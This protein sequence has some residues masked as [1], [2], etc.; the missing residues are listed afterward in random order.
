MNIAEAMKIAKLI[1]ARFPKLALL[2]GEAGILIEFHDFCKQEPLATKE[3]VI[4]CLRYGLP[5][6]SLYYVKKDTHRSFMLP[7]EEYPEAIKK[8]NL[9]SFAL[10]I[11]MCQLHFKSY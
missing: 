7:K 4:S 10:M 6:P 3:E 9:Q 5:E 1:Q 8:A 2:V 11:E